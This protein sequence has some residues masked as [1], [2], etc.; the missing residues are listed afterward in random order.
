MTTNTHSYVPRDVYQPRGKRPWCTNCDTDVHLLVES[1]PVTGRRA[2]TL[3]VAVHCSQCRASR[4]L[5]TTADHVA[6][7]PLL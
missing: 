3:A 7:L 1:P 2:G 5:D 6:A 4:V